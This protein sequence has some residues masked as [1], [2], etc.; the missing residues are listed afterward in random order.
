MQKIGNPEPQISYQFVDEATKVL[1]NGDLLL[2]RENWR[3]TN[4]FVPGFWGHAAVYKDGFAIEAIGTGVRR[5]N[6]YRWMYQ[7]DSIAIL[8]PRSG[9][10]EL[11]ASIAEA[12]IGAE[13]DFLFEPN[14]KAFYCSEL[15][16]YSY[17]WAH[18]TKRIYLIDQFGVETSTPQD[19]YN[20][21]ENVF[22][23]I[24]E[25]RN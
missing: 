19:L 21:R 9:N 11:I 15:Y 6:I 17:N 25:E 10:G 20:L 2:S 12:Q 8:R 5:E 24:K 14:A 22:D 18:D 16:V 4:P 3:L 23:V 1:K 7:K 13:Y